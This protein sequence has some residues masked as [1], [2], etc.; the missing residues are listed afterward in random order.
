MLLEL[1][2]IGKITLLNQF[3]SASS[4]SNI[5]HG[6][7][8]GLVLSRH[9]QPRTFL[10][11]PTSNWTCIR[12]HYIISPPSSF[13]STLSYMLTVNMHEP[14]NYSLADISAFNGDAERGVAYCQLSRTGRLKCF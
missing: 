4:L 11:F 2:S 1:P 3:P 6:S 14:V 7:V 12:V 9:I 13:P 5:P 10:D 8:I